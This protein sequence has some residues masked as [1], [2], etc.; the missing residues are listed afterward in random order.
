MNLGIYVESLKDGVQFDISNKIVSYATHNNSFDDTSVFYEDIGHI[1]Q[2]LSCGM[3]NSTDIWNFEGKLLIFSL[4]SARKCFDIVNN[5][6]LYYYMGLESVNVPHLLD[7]INRG[8][9]IICMTKTSK[10][11]L[12]R[13]TGNFPVG[14][15]NRPDNIVRY[16]TVSS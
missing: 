1:S 6:E 3:F 4:E 13:L 7:L 16:M 12:Y 8:V 10:K 2:N 14:T 11:Q 9:K 5:F 15:S